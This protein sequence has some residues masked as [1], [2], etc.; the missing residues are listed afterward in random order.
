MTCLKY[1]DQLI[2]YIEGTLTSKEEEEF[3]QHLDNCLGCQRALEQQREILMLL[4][5]EVNRIEIP[6]DFI[7]KV[8][9]RLNQQTPKH[10]RKAF[11]WRIAAVAVALCILLFSTDLTTGMMNG[12]LQWWQG[13]SGNQLASGNGSEIYGEEVNITA[14]DQDIR[15]T[16]THVAADEFGTDVYY[17]IEDLN[18]ERLFDLG[19]HPRR[20]PSWIVLKEENHQYEHSGYVFLSSPKPNIFKGRVS[21]EAIHGEHTNVTL[22]INSLD[23]VRQVDENE[24]YPFSNHNHRIQSEAVK[25]NWHFEI[26][27]QKAQTKTYEVK[28]ELDIAGNSVIID[29]IKVTPQRTVLQYSYYDKDYSLII[30]VEKLEVDGKSYYSSNYRSVGS[31]NSNGD[32]WFDVGFEPI[33]TENPEEIKIHFGTIK[34][35]SQWTEEYPIDLEQPFPQSFEYQETTVSINK[36]EIGNPTIIEV[37][38]EET[39]DFDHLEID[40]QIKN[41]EQRIWNHLNTNNSGYALDELGNRYT[42]EQIYSKGFPRKVRFIT[43][44]YRFELSLNNGFNQQHY[45]VIPIT[46]IISGYSQTEFLN[47]IVTIKLK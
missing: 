36:V 13:I 1:E 40:F 19:M 18:Q 28:Q 20:P 42:N 27:I 47:D 16:I 45:D 9:E 30:G 43:T 5:Q 10:R 24:G 8:E 34:K 17:E 15:I 14:V 26:P 2:D 46:M 38:T 11:G 41:D 23:L 39:Q 44:K 25:G 33:L 3:R 4:D 22:S 12:V 35:R 6:Y 32:H 7:E 31:W 37:S 29:A 21:Y